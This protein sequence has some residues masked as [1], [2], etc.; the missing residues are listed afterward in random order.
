MNSR[1]MSRRVARHIAWA[2]AS[3]ALL[4]MPVAAQPVSNA[5]QAATAEP[6]VPLLQ[7]LRALGRVIAPAETR[8]LLAGWSTDTGAGVVLERD[9]AYGP[10]PRHRLDIAAA[11]GSQNL[12]VLVFVH[13]GG[14]TAGERRLPDTPYF[15]NVAI[16]AVR[17]GMV[18]VSITYRLAPA[19]PWPAGAQ[20]VGL[21]LRWLRDEVAARG[22]DPRRMFVFGHSSGATHVASYLAD[23]SASVPTAPRLAGALLL[24]GIYRIPAD[25]PLP[26]NVVAYYGAERQAWPA[27]SPFGGLLRT[28]VALWLGW[29]ELDPPNLEHQAQQLNDALCREDR[30]PAIARLADHN[31]MSAPYS[32]G[33]DDPTVGTQVLAFVRSRLHA[34]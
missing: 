28:P 19:H 24:S 34:P 30:C 18:G 16:W 26:P 12:P 5:P 3:V 10:D 6:G 29:C 25:A 20:D 7:P 11:P 32:L 8:R 15:D 2:A 31:H 21:A 9:L 14:F 1:T 33:S 22:G 27:R 4:P 23:A 17:H 13:G